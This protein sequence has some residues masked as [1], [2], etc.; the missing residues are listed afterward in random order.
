M[1]KPNP[2]LLALGAAM[3]QP[4]IHACAQASEEAPAA[5]GQGIN[6]AMNTWHAVL[7]PLEVQ[8]DFLIV[9]RGGPGNNLEEFFFD[10]PYTVG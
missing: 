6:Y 5:P 4:A 8:S 10:E 2:L 3:L 1:N 7:T 9:D